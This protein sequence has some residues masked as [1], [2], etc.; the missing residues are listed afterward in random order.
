RE[1]GKD[2]KRHFSE[3]TFWPE[4]TFNQKDK[5]EI[6]KIENVTD[7][8]SH[9]ITIRIDENHSIIPSQYVLYAV[10]IKE[11]AIALRDHLDVFDNFKSGKSR[12]EIGSEIFSGQFDLSPQNLDEWSKS[13][14]LKPIVD[15]EYNFDA[16][17]IINGEKGNYKVRGT[18]DFFTSVIL[19]I[20]NV[21]DA[22]SSILG[23]FIYSLCSNKELYNYLEKRFYRNLPYLIKEKK[24]N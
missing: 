16:K 10:F 8:S 4:L 1:L 18:S 3:I 17:S 7:V 22:S 24:S 12:N 13:I 5:S 19:K 9:S 15:A 21:P 6:S 20:I 14:A 2:L 23:K 11:F